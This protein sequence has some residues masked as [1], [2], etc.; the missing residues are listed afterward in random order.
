MKQ[1]IIDRAK[2]VNGKY[3]HG[4]NL[5]NSYGERCCLGFLG[6]ACG[7]YDSFMRSSGYPNVH[8]GG[9][10]PELFANIELFIGINDHINVDDSVREK[11]IIDAFKTKLNFE[12]IFIGNYPTPR[13]AKDS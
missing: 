8:M 4:S 11:Q 3:G 1:V 5:L 7:V 12:V 13:S 10:P 9:F 6:Q 2:W